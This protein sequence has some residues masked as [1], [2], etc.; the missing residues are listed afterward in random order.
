[1]TPEDWRRL[2]GILN[3]ALP[4]EADARD[5][6]LEQACGGD[7]ELLAQCRS[8]ITSDE[9]PWPML[10]DSKPSPAPMASLAG[11]LLESRSPRTGERVGAYEILE[12]IGHGG[13]GT[14]YLGRRADEAFRKKVAIKL[15][16]AGMDL[17]SVLRRF[18][19]E[20]QILANL[21]HPHIARLLDGGATTDGRPYFVMEYIEGRTLPDWCT[22]KGL[23]VRERL[24]LF[25]DV[26]GAVEYAHQNLVVHRD[27]KPA[28]ILV[29]NDGTAKLLDFGIA[30][31]IVPELF[32]ASVEETGTLFRLL[33]PDYA[34]PEQVRG[35]PVTPAS[36]VYALGVV[37]YELLTG[38]RPYQAGA[39]AAE[40]VRVVCETE[41]P[42]PSERATRPL[43]RELSGDLDT[44]VMKALR[45]EPARRYAD[46]GAMA[47]DI[48]RFLEDRPVL[49]RPDTV[50][51]RARRF[52]RRHWGGLTAAAIASM[53]L[54]AGAVAIRREAAPT[55][56][57][58]IAASAASTA[59][60][61][62][63][64]RPLASQQHDAILEQGIADT[65]IAK[66]SGVPGI[67]VRP[68]SAVLPYSDDHTDSLRAG[69][70]LR[71]DAVLE[72]GVQRVGDRIRVN[73]RLV[74]VS[75]GRPIW[76]ET[77]D[78]LYTSVFDVQDAIAQRVAEA[79]VPSLSPAERARLS[80]RGTENL[81]A[82]RAYLRGRYFWNR[83]TEADFRK[84]IEAFSQAIE[85]DPEYGLA[86][87]GLADCHSLLGVWGAASPR[88]T[89][90][91]AEGAA[92]RAVARED[93]PAEAH[94]SLALVRWVY[95]WDASGAEDQFRRAIALNAGYAT[96]HQWLAYLLAAQGRF[97]EAVAEIERAQELD[98]LSVSIMSD[99]GD[100]HLWAGRYDQAIAHVREALELEPN[101]AV[102]HNVLGMAL[103]KQQRTGEAIRELE[104]AARLEELPRMLSTLGYAYAVTGR[105][106]D[107]LRIRQ[108]LEALARTRYVS[109][110]A[111][112]VV[113]T[114]LGRA[115][116]AF[117]QLER[118]FAEHSDTMAIL[119]AY[120]LFESLRADPRF[121]DVLRRVEARDGG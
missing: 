35:E 74:R 14:V 24:R 109:P 62:L 61:V 70:K 102:A 20:R 25:L 93:A 114:G 9:A 100:I 65:L 88:E 76:G 42:K 83:R 75:D 53:S 98:P 58:A 79:L 85:A 36:D 90:G 84:A 60:A 48:R 21:E 56:N 37:L 44:I 46:A 30:K 33:T 28:N 107:A 113:D 34:S 10:D 43:A 81:T 3:E 119:R 66:L 72:G 80:G 52:A 50:G 118:A 115:D 54:V 117:A 1:M 92:R 26:C 23:G 39:S 8:L 57:A 19:T 73:V 47:D 31:L 82:Y 78:T 45:K 71:A 95:G 103:L 106:D 97:D 22:E 112:A 32:G 51:Y 99:I 17:D 105:R 29:T 6:Y 13:M 15:V 116:S 121:A 101:Y 5:A 64:F 38:R 7:A 16:R 2:K 68:V 67:A 77:F 55:P 27:I 111:L 110:F 63:P 59:L 4:L 86:Y 11:A 12:E 41:V 89:F 91:L 94:A 18:R 69:R 120:P 104:L 108:R 96:A 49:A 87:A 40:M